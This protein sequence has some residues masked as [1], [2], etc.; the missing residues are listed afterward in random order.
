LEIWFNGGED[1]IVEVNGNT[2]THQDYQYIQQLNDIIKD[3][4]QLG[5]FELGNLQITVNSLH[6]YQ[7]ELI[8]L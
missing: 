1:V 6:E 2:F 5:T 3:N 4:N 8:Y 7:D